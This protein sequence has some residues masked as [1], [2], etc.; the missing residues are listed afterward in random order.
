[1]PRGRKDVTI[2]VM[3]QSL[4]HMTETM[5]HLVHIA[6]VITRVGLARIVVQA[7]VEEEEAGAAAGDPETRITP[8]AMHTR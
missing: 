4:V 2:H 5:V 1:M 6:M 7:V 8:A 3:A